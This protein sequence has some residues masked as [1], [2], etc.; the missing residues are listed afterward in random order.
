M[1]GALQGGSKLDLRLHPDEDR[2]NKLSPS[3][4]KLIKDTKEKISQKPVTDV[5]VAIPKTSVTT[6]G[7]ASGLKSATD[8][9][10][11]TL[12]RAVTTSATASGSKAATV[13][14][15][16][17][18]KRS[19]TTVGTASGLKSPTD[20]KEAIPRKSVADVKATISKK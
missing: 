12:Q 1:K 13:G 3:G 5:K 18:L 7:T 8:A 9:K 20:G 16:A 14:K 10:K 17:M 19:V 4:L 11:P 2:S 6:S 15:E